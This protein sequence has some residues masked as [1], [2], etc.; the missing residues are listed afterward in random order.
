MHMAAAA[1]AP[2]L[3]LFGPSDE[4]LYGPWGAKG[5]AVRGPRQFAEF[6]AIDPTF[7][8]AMCHMLDLAPAPVIAAARDL[9]TATESEFDSRVDPG[10]T[11]KNSAEGGH[12]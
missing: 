3:G 7:S 6:R 8:Q 2:T 9:I 10:R 5:R 4:T 11:S 1:G 12:G